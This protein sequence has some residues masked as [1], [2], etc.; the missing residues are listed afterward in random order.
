MSAASASKITIQRVSA[1][2]E[3]TGTRPNPAFVGGFI[4]RIEN[5]SVTIS[6]AES[7]VT[8]SVTGGS[9]V[10]GFIATMQG[11]SVVTIEKSKFTGTVDR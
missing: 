1:E 10:G 6:E 5:G 11:A 8:I 9:H 7:A 4:G 3:I 2:T